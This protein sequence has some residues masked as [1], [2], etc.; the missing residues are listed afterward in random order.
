MRTCGAGSETEG[1]RPVRRAHPGL[2]RDQ[3]RD[4]APL[5]QVVQRCAGRAR[6]GEGRGDHDGRHTAHAAQISTLC[7]PPRHAAGARGPRCSILGGTAAPGS[8]AGSWDRAGR[9]RSVRAATLTL[10]LERGF[11]EGTE[12]TRPHEREAVHVEEHAADL[13]RAAGPGVSKTGA[14]VPAAPAPPSSGALAAGWGGCVGR[15]GYLAAGAR[16]QQCMQ[17]FCLTCT[18]WDT[19]ELGRCLIYAY[20]QYRDGLIPLACLRN[21][22]GLGGARLDDRGVERVERDDLAQQRRPALLRAQLRAV[23]E[24]RDDE[25]DACRGA[26]ASGLRYSREP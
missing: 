7:R 2:R 17:D 19:G 9:L 4:D 16:A 20:T 21:A 5:R 6:V 8:P 26:R 25:Q 18:G 22:R 10:V 13:A 15:A 11:G 1:Q 23:R 3:V 14:G 24:V 12:R